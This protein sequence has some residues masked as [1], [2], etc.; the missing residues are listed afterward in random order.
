MTEELKW[1]KEKPDYACVFLTRHNGNYEL[2]RF[3]WE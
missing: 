1:Q 3:S 2:W